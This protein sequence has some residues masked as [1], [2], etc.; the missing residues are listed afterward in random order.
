VSDGQ[1]IQPSTTSTGQVESEISKPVSVL[2][3]LNRQHS[4]F[5][6][7]RGLCLSSC[8]VFEH[9][10]KFEYSGTQ[11]TN[12]NYIHEEINSRENS[13]N[14][15]CCGGRN[16]SFRLLP[17]KYKTVALPVFFRVGV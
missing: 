4:Q 7:Q 11:L 3:I 9:V 16:F 14:T 1:I 15:C 17:K 5:I 10:A 2:H 12:Q 6:F 8:N 13:G